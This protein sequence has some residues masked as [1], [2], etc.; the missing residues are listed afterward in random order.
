[1]RNDSQSFLARRA[2]RSEL[3]KTLV[4]DTGAAVIRISHDLGLFANLLRPRERDVRRP[5]R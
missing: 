5:G 1:M 4:K 2:I 3:T